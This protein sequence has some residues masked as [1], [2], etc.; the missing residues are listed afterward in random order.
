MP[1]SVVF[2]M[3]SRRVFLLSLLV[4]AA[5][6]SCNAHTEAAHQTLH[7]TFGLVCCRFR[8]H[9]CS[10]VTV[11]CC[12]ADTPGTCDPGTYKGPSVAAIINW[13][14]SVGIVNH[15]FTNDSGQAVRGLVAKHD[16][17]PHTT[18]ISMQRNMAL[19]MIIGQKS[20][21]PDLITD[22]A[23]RSCGE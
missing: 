12:T 10:S 14:N 5:Q 17:P 9:A 1:C 13:A 20:P 21:Y 11:S 3:T 15:R 19:T 2:C 7:G 16:I 18:L 6:P 4:L 8:A 23:W 22:D